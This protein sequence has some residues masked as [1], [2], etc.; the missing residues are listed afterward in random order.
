M[1]SSPRVVGAAGFALAGAL[2]IIFTPADSLAVPPFEVPLAKAV[3]EADFV[4][5]VEVMSV[6]APPK[7]G[8]RASAPPTVVAR[9]VTVLKGTESVGMSIVWQT[10]CP[11][12]YLRDRAKVEIVP[13]KAGDEYMVYLRKGND[14]TFA[15]FGYFHHFHPMPAAPTVRV[16]PSDYGSW[17]GLI[18]VSPPVAAPG[19]AVRYRFTRT[20]LAAE[21]W[22][23]D[24]SNLTAEDIDA[25][26]V[27]RKRVLDRKKPGVRKTSPVVIK[28]G[29]TVADVIDLTA[30][31][32]IAEP[33]EYWVFR[34]GADEDA[35][36]LRFTVSDKL[37]VRTDKE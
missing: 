20:R 18:E 30:A 14:G 4:G 1:R 7:G 21:A 15:R 35:G 12:C 31:F 29:E 34:R 6:P 23:G 37:R 5:I 11:S 10:Y 36:P 3:E 26:D 19:E 28:Q 33:G 27:A 16:Q 8:F 13:P 22:T 17:R 24:E 2:L 9:T 25:I 32:G